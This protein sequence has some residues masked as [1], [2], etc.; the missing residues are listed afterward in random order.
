MIYEKIEESGIHYKKA[1][2]K[3]EV[4][5]LGQ[6]VGVSNII[7]TDAVFLEAYIECDDNQWKFLSFP[8]LIQTQTS[9]IDYRHFACFSHPFDIHLTTENIHGWPR[10]VVRIF[11]FGDDDKAV[12]LSYGTCLLPNTSGY[13]EIEFDTWQLGENIYNETL[14]FFM[15][16]KPNLSGM[17][18]VNSDLSD[19]VNIVA[20]PGPKVHINV[21]VILRNFSFQV[22]SGV[23]EKEK[24]QNEEI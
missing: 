16:S 2:F 23:E 12:L 14:S 5:F 24:E 3:V 13:H 20:K 19:R 17:D 6:I 9:F 1:D 21:E 18:P 22:L 4:H 15:E 11:K 8:K 10:M 7:E